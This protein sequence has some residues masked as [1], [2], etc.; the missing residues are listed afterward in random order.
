MAITRAQIR[1]NV[2]QQLGDLVVIR[3]TADS[4]S[5][6]VFID[7]TNL[8]LQPLAYSGRQVVFASG[9][10]ANIGLIRWVQGSSM[11]HRSLTFTDALPTAPVTGDTAHMMNWRGVGWTVDDYNMAINRAIRN[12]GQLRYMEWREDTLVAADY[13]TTTRRLTIPDDYIY[14]EELAFQTYDDA[15]EEAWMGRF[16]SGQGWA[17]A[18][19]DG[20]LEIGTD[21]FDTLL[22][23]DPIFRVRGWARPAELLADD[24][25]TTVPSSW[26]EEEVMMALLRRHLATNPSLADIHGKLFADSARRADMLNPTMSFNFGPFATR[27]RP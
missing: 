16:N 2:G 19:L 1:E 7:R 9:T 24:D 5:A 20:T 22:Y 14:V 15:W 13:N 23:P 11:E 10:P 6:S 3:A 21:V 18:G 25:E 8:V 4:P 12:A 26:L 17:G 27:V